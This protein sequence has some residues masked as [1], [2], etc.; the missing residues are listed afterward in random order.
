MVVI[1]KK[2]NEVIKVGDAFIKVKK[3]SSGI[4]FYIQAQPEVKISRLDELKKEG[5]NGTK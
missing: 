4:K 1:S 3:T 2:Y 5:L